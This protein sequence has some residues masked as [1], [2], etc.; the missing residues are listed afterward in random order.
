[1]GRSQGL[2]FPDVKT[3]ILFIFVLAGLLSACATEMNALVQTVRAA[4]SGGPAA[5][6]S[7]LDPRFS[8]LRIT[9]GKR[10]AFLALGFFDSDRHGQVE[11]WYSGQKEAIR[12]QDGRV[13]GAVGLATEWRGVMLP[14]LPSWS[15]IAQSKEPLSW[16]RV[17]DV[18]PGYRFDLRDGLVL[19]QIPPPER[20]ALLHIDP[21]EL[22]WFEERFQQEPVAGIMP[23]F[24]GA[25]VNDQALPPAR[26]AVDLRDG[27]EFVVYGEQCLSA[28]FCFTW[29]RWHYH[30]TE[31]K[32]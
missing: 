16:V 7:L 29:Q 25:T 27:M 21:R 8:Y 10:V 31:Q 23:L 5:D 1:M 13:I 6:M 26:Y 18:M 20:S 14:D 30:K 12:L 19:R 28:D 4:A 9:V 22:T 32:P 2:G 3:R 15:V 24:Q 11:V 17:R